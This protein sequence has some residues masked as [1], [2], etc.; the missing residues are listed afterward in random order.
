M[1]A[2]PNPETLLYQGGGLA[3]G[4][5]IY[6][7]RGNMLAFPVFRVSKS[8][9]LSR[10][11]RILWATWPWANPLDPKNSARHPHLRGYDDGELADGC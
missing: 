11:M 2:H 4:P 8:K 9:P 6:G 3:E 1:L 10:L 7:I 5:H